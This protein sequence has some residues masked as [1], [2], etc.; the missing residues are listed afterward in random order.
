M[1]EQDVF[2]YSVKFYYKHSPEICIVLKDVSKQD[3]LKIQSYFENKINLIPIGSLEDSISMQIDIN[4][5]SHVE[6]HKQ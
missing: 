4:S 2:L 1:K 5:I 6:Y 3:C